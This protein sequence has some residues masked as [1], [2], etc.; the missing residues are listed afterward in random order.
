MSEVKSKWQQ[1]AEIQVDPSFMK[2]HMI[3]CKRF[4]DEG[5]VR[6][7]ATP[8]GGT[9]LSSEVKAKREAARKVIRS[10]YSKMLTEFN[11]DIRNLE[12][13]KARGKPVSEQLLSDT[14][15][16]RIN[17]LNERKAKLREVSK[18]IN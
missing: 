16:E 12:D 15:K 4:P 2:G 6:A 11:K 5:L 13:M 17:M 18:T 10:K 7:Y 9:A 8:M 14:R 3:F 1:L